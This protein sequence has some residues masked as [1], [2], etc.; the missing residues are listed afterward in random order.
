VDEKPE[1]LA[2]EVTDGFAL[3]YVLIG[4]HV[5]TLIRLLQM[6]SDE[7]K[8]CY[9]FRVMASS[10]SRLRAGLLYFAIGS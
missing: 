4:I 5:S 2:A 9:V 7:A 8:S 6:V 3:R 1:G 10:G